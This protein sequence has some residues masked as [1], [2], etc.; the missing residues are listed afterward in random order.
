MSVSDPRTAL[1]PELDVYPDTSLLITEDGKPVDNLFVEKQYRLLTEPLWSSWSAPDGKPFRVLA[2]VGLF[3]KYRDPPLVP[4]VMFASDAESP[5]AARE[6]DNRSYFV[7]IVGKPPDVV[8]EI[9]SDKRGREDSEKLR[10]YERIRVPFYVIFDPEEI[11]D[12]GVLRAYA[13]H[14]EKYR[15]VD[16]ARFGSLGLGLALWEGE[17]EGSQ[18]TWLRW[19]NF[20]GEVIPTGKEKAEAERLRAEAAKDRADAEKERADAE[21]DRADAEKD[22]ADA[23]KDRANAAEERT[24]RLEERLRAAGLS[25]NGPM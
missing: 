11:L 20:Q 9:V 17:Y 13:M 2:N 8:I 15:P 22:R 4:D 23:E 18:D 6:S 19:T 5:K 10:A 3:F 14:E 16:P 1:D 7:W 21:K 24:R 12:G 25:A